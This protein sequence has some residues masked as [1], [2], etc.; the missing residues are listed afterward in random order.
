MCVLLTDVHVPVCAT[1]AGSTS[2]R[3]EGA[4]NLA[5]GYLNSPVANVAS[6][7]VHYP[8]SVMAPRGEYCKAA[9]KGR[10]RNLARLKF[11]LTDTVY[12]L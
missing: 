4:R 3:H 1:Y 2:R 7:L 11:T 6:Q 5:E 10:W 12:C 9:P 8:C